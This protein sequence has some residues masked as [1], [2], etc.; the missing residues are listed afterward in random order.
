LSRRQTERGSRFQVEIEDGIRL[1]AVN[2]R[3]DDVE[4]SVNTAVRLWWS[5]RLRGRR[6]SHLIREARE[7][8]QARISLGRIEHGEP[9]QRV[10]MPYFFAV[11]RALVEQDRRSRD[12]RRSPIAQ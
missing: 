1:A 12:P 5:S 4:A 2:F 9:G 3:D 8:T 7:V 6:F 11:L 10:A